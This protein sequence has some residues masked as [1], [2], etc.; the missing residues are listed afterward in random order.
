MSKKNLTK[1][2]HYVPRM[3]LKR[4]QCEN[5]EKLLVITKKVQDNGIKTVTVDDNLFYQEY[6]YDIIDLDGILRTSNEVEK[7]LGV[8]ENKHNKL[9]ERILRRCE[10]DVPVF[11]N[12]TNRIKD[13]LGFI[14]LMVV[15]NPNNSILFSID[16]I[17]FS[18]SE[19]ND[20]FQ[21]MFGKKCKTTAMQLVS[22]SIDKKHLFEI[23][24]Q[25]NQIENFPEIYFLKS[26]DEA[27]FITSDN[28]VLFCGKWSYIPLS[29]SYAAFILYDTRLKCRFKNN[30]VFQ[31]S[32][33]EVQKLNGVYW[34]QNDVF[35]IVGN[36][37]KDL[38]DAL[39]I[40]V[41]R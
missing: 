32:I 4:W 3:Y 21:V 7:N 31:L 30:G 40:E 6:C 27:Y 33:S 26:P 15:R 18:T 39:E 8:Y 2:Q 22:N 29:P 36:R 28:P 37:D 24:E 5:E 11:D 13:F 35:T 12:G 19:L 20:L 1:K 41:K 25:T 16:S 9:L 34:K 17:I 38:I 23:V 14:T 10:E